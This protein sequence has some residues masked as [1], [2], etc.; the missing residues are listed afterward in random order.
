MCFH[1]KYV[2]MNFFKEFY[3]TVLKVLFMID[4]LNLRTMTSQVVKTEKNMYL[5]MY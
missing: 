4:I 2:I 1:I 5:F 3:Y